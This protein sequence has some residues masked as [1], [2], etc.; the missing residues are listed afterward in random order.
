LTLQQP[1]NLRGLIKSGKVLIGTTLS[2]PSTHVARTVAVTGA[3]ICWLDAE[4]VA[5][6][7]QVL[8][9]CIQT[10]IHVSDGKMIPVVQVPS[11]TAFEYMVNAGAAGIIVPH[12]ETLE[13][14]KAVIDACRFPPEGHR[15]FPPFTLVPGVTDTVP[16]GENLFS[17][18]NKHVAIIPQIESL[19]GIE[20]LEAMLKLDEVS[21]VMIGYGALRLELKLPSG[22][23]STS[24]TEPKY[25]AAIQKVKDISKGLNIPIVGPATRPQQIKE[26]V[27]QGYRLIVCCLD[28]HTLAGGMIK[29]INDTRDLVEGHMQSTAGNY[30]R[31]RR[32]LVLH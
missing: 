6:S 5:W 12:L 14:M 2:Y 21:A 30:T 10:I 18:A 26:R 11:K 7:P 19:R 9:E 4:H 24:G 23:T 20:N 1:T 28:M 29:S 27:D 13:E 22:H 8:V 17:V 25:V 31:N 15:S 16:D 32:S 3:D